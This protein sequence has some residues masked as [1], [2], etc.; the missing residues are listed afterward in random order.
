MLV[1]I[2]NTIVFVL[3]QSS[4]FINIPQHPPILLEEIECNNKKLY[5]NLM[6]LIDQFGGSIELDKTARFYRISM[7]DRSAYLFE[8][9]NQIVTEKAYSMEQPFLVTTDLLCIPYDGVIKVLSFFVKDLRTIKIEESAPSFKGLLNLPIYKD[10]RKVRIV[11]DPGHG[12]EDPGARSATGLREKDVALD[13]A[14]ILGELLEEAGFEVILTREEDITLPLPHRVAIANSS[15]GELFLSIHLNSSNNP[16][17]SG[18][19]FFFLNSTSSDEETNELAIRENAGY[20]IEV[21]NPVVV[22]IINELNKSERITLSK[23]FA[24]ELY[25]CAEHEL[26]VRR[27]IRQAPFYV[28]SGIN[29]PGVLVEVGFISN[30]HESELLEDIEYREK[31]AEV[32]A[33]GIR[34]FIEKKGGKIYYAEKG[35]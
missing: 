7:D 27:G 26:N 31:V 30:K 19:E 11:I 14:L 10:S 3:F 20:K 33:L 23:E 24:E 32:I 6:E 17:A 5:Y 28:L 18:M 8:N 9:S 12:G 16:D 21:Q 25:S 1:G 34:R 29:M 13:I 15:G 4:L 22:E 2:L 35:K